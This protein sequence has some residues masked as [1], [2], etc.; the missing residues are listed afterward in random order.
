[1]A[2]RPSKKLD[3]DGVWGAKSQAMLD[4]VVGIS[5]TGWSGTVSGSFDKAYKKMAGMARL[6]LQN[7]LNRFRPT[8][9]YVYLGSIWGIES[10]AKLDVDGVWGSATSN[11][12]TNFICRCLGC[13]YSSGGKTGTN[14]AGGWGGV[15]GFSVSYIYETASIKDVQKFL[16]AAY[17]GKKLNPHPEHAN[18]GD[19]LV[20]PRWT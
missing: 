12:L 8:W 13:K 17:E 18:Y 14:M 9:Q 20:P 16:N 4:Y 11:A 19:S 5:A 3:T 1:M 10:M 7:Y 15:S 2:P 6:G